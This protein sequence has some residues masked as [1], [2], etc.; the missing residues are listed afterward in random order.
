M[1]DKRT[2]LIGIV[3]VLL[4]VN[5][6]LFLIDKGVSDEDVQPT[7]IYFTKLESSAEMDNFKKLV[8]ENEEYLDHVNFRFVNPKND[9]FAAIENHYS[10]KS[11][12]ALLIV[13][14]NGKIIK[15]YTA[16]PSNEQLR[17][18]LNKYVK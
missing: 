12:S 7:V 2:L 5:A 8:V 14:S 6:A 9:D 4:I 17:Q 10:V 13:S 1:K 11:A 15:K 18:V 3:V 16:I